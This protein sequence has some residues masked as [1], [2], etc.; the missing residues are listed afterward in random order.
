MWDGM[1]VQSSGPLQNGFS[2]YLVQ[3]NP[4]LKGYSES[5]NF[6]VKAALDEINALRGIISIQEGENYKQHTEI[7]LFENELNETKAL[8]EKK[9]NEIISLLSLSDDKSRSI[10]ELERELESSKVERGAF[11]RF[12]EQNKLLLDRLQVEKQK[13]II[14]QDELKELRQE[15]VDLKKMKDTWILGARE[16]EAAQTLRIR[17]LSD[18]IQ[19]TRGRQE[20]AE[21]EALNLKKTVVL[22]QQELKFSEERRSDETIRSRRINYKTIQKMEDMN[23]NYRKIMDDHE[24]ILSV[25]SHIDNRSESLCRQ[26][27]EKSQD[28]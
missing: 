13:N 27:M 12:A 16:L 25:N 24:N 2:Q 23:Y 28:L 8:L 17:D 14:A 10:L 26:L 9:Q 19:R 21:K 7:E 1:Y 18:E 15:I 11:Q 5:R 3:M 6:A 22:L 20:L 4:D